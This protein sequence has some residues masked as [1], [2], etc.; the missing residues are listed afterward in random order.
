MSIA[1]GI[2][3]IIIGVLF[4]VRP[5]LFIRWIWWGKWVSEGLLPMKSYKTYLAVAGVV[6]LVV[7][8]LYLV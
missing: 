2:F 7:G 3:H 6:I 5:T 4:I 8:V 1:L